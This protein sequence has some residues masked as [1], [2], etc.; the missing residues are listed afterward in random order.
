MRYSRSG[1]LAGTILDKESGEPLAGANI[2]VKGTSIGAASNEEGNFQLQNI[3]A[4]AQEVIF[5]YVGYSTKTL[6]IESEAKNS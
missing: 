5:S 4:D 2:I 1:S 6:Q 3:P